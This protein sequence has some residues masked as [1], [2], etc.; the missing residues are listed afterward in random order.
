[1]ANPNKNSGLKKYSFTH[2]DKM[3]IILEII[4]GASIVIAAIIAAI[5]S[6]VSNNNDNHSETTIVDNHSE[7]I[8]VNNNNNNNIYISSE[9]NNKDELSE[10]T[11]TTTYND[12]VLYEE[13]SAF[14]TVPSYTQLPS[15]SVSFTEPM[16][17]TET[18][19]SYDT[20]PYYKCK[21]ESSK[22]T[23][24]TVDIWDVFSNDHSTPKNQTTQ[25]SS[26]N[27]TTISEN[28]WS[29]YVYEVTLEKQE[30]N[31]LRF[32]VQ[33]DLNLFSLPDE[34]IWETAF[35]SENTS[36]AARLTTIGKDILSNKVMIFEYKN[37][38]Y[39]YSDT[40]IPISSYYDNTKDI[41]II[42]VLIDDANLFESASLKNN[43]ISEI[44]YFN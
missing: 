44:H 29:D 17:N 31:L 24:T 30:P 19:T 33:G 28:I 18:S 35:K 7:P 27:E 23:T 26:V 8:I 42:E 13:T 6:S 20:E 4:T 10:N 16:Y 25:K 21:S 12:T 3:K 5:G 9:S 22:S 39:Y 43:T 2:K 15:T 32:T 34:Q 38:G 11:T 1:M 14:S 37:G 40:D 36:Y 41:F